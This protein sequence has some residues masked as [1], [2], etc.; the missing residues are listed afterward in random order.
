MVWF[1]VLGL[2]RFKISLDLFEIH[3]DLV[4]ILPDF[5][6]I[7]LDLVEISSRFRLISLR[8]AKISSKSGQSSKNKQI[9]AK[10]GNESHNPSPT[11]NQPENDDVQPLEPLPSA[12]GGKSRFRRPE[13]IRSV[14]GWAQTRP[15]DRPTLSIKSN[16]EFVIV[17]LVLEEGKF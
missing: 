15:V 3:R 16:N 4:K 13:V 5:F 14:P 17:D 8:S 9:L 10:S 2:C 7:G 1:K 6:K 11:E 12:V